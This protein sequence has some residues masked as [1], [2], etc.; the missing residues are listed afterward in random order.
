MLKRMKEN[1]SKDVKLKFDL[2]D[3]LNFYASILPAKK[4]MYGLKHIFFDCIFKLKPEYA[5]LLKN[6]TI[7]LDTFPF[8]KEFEYILSIEDNM[9]VIRSNM[10]E[11]SIF[12][13]ILVGS[14]KTLPIEVKNRGIFISLAMHYLK[15]CLN[16]GYKV[17]DVKDIEA[18]ENYNEGFD[19][20]MFETIAFLPTD[21]RFIGTIHF[22]GIDLNKDILK[23]FE[24]YKDVKFTYNEENA[25]F[26]I[27]MKASYWDDFWKNAPEYLKNEFGDE[28]DHKMDLL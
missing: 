16:S 14:I 19:K 12:S 22:I 8:L 2:I 3:T 1:G 6:F 26:I 15:F 27:S 21:E 17:C 24:D 4:D 25:S 7:T 11:L 23:I 13:L 18:L 9:L 20:E 5:E 28:Q 10:E